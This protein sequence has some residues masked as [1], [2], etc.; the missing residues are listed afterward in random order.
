MYK[1]KSLALLLLTALSIAACSSDKKE[2]ETASV[3]ELYSKANTYLLDENY[4]EAI[5]YLD[6]V[7]SRYP[8]GA[9]AEQAQLGL[10]YANY[11]DSEYTL[12]L[13]NAERFLRLHSNSQ[14]LDFVLYLAGLINTELG[15]HFLQKAF[16]T[17]R[18]SRDPLTLTNALH[19]FETLQQHFPNSQYAADAAVRANYLRNALA[20]HEQQVAEFY[21]KRHAYVAT[22]N[23]VLG[24]LDT[25]PDTQ[26]THEA[27]PLLEKSYQA[28]KLNEPAAKI[29]ELIKQ[30]ENKT[31]AEIPVP[32][33]DVDLVVPNVLSPTAQ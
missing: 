19:N 8:F 12:A 9:Y 24:L 17:D 21:F 4:A 13:A 27:L 32:E 7:D 30:G 22:V 5:R 25:Y 28:M 16:G 33:G 14:H 3:E 31:F 18:A 11:K 15:D 29:A 10:I 1:L 6:A 2:V 20:R 23:R 26:A